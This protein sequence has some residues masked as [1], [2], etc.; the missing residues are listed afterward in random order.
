MLQTFDAPNGDFSCVRRSRSNTPLQALT[1]LNEPVFLESA[2]ALA[3]AALKEGGATDS[4]RLVFAFR[5]CLAR[6][7]DDA[8]SRPLLDLLARETARFGS[9]AVDPW[10]LTVD[11]PEEALRL[12]ATATPA[13]FAAWTVVSRVLLNLDET[14]TK[15]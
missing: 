13:Q 12:P 6:R 14:I 10:D 3:L 7:P 11:K 1:L 9:G 2:R 8:E 5:R 4:E 15:E